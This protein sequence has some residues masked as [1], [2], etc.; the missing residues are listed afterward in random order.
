MNRNVPRSNNSKDTSKV[1]DY[2][3]RQLTLFVNPRDAETIERVRQKYNPI[4]FD[5]IKA[6]VTLCREDEIH[7]MEQVMTN[8]SRLT[9]TEIVIDFGKIERFD[10]GKGLLLPATKDNSDFQALRKNI[11][12]GLSEN[13]RIHE[14]H[15]T[16]M[17]PRNSTCTDDIFEQV[18][19][20]SLP[21]KLEFK[22][23]SLIEQSNGGQWRVLQEISVS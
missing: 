9:Q 21:T 12:L 13:P 6:H 2:I 3:R 1:T 5:L 14:P 10:K 20:L 22:R 15:I 11:L 18:E 16:L 7:N 8:L 23:I 17:H 19:K 4:Q